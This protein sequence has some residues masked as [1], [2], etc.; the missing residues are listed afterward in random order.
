MLIKTKQFRIQS[1]EFGFKTLKQKGKQWIPIRYLFE[2]RINT[3]LKD[4]IIDFNDVKNLEL[5]KTRFFE[6]IESIKKEILGG[7][8]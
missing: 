3:E 5:Q 7:L 4:F 1:Y 2:Y 8:K 6:K